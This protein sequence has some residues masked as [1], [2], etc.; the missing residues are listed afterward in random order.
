MRHMLRQSAEE[1]GCPREQLEANMESL[2][3]MVRQNGWS[4]LVKL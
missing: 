4:N 2:N 1:T 3:C